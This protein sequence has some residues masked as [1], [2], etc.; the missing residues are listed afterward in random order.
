[1]TLSQ[2]AINALERTNDLLTLGHYSP[3]TARNYSAQLRWLFAYYP[4]V[5]PSQI[6]RPMTLDYLVYLAKTLG[7]SRTKLKMAAQSFA[8]FFR[9]VLNKPY[10]VPSVLFP[11]HHDKLPAVMRTD[12]V[13]AI[14]DCIENIKHRTLVSLLYST[15]MRIS[16]VANLKIEDIDSTD[17]RIK[18]CSGKGDKDRYTLLSPQLL[19]ELR[20]YYR[21][22]KPEVYL[23][24]GTRKGA[25]YST[26]SIQHIVAVALEKTGLQHKG[27]TVHTF[28]HSFATHLLNHGADLLTIKEL[29]GHANISQ[30][31]HYLHLSNAHTKNVVNPLDMLYNQAAPSTPK[32]RP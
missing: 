27:F 16:E 24:N 14:I 6:T 21:A 17:M 7:S 22:F 30:T 31:L 29:L 20:G 13:K 11:A 5:R 8:F 15:G 19:L 23:F 4:E 18:V 25:K 2:W 3:D 12:E 1:M 28:R 9:Q 10:E 26:R 32:R